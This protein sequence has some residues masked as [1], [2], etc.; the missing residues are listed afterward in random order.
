MK[1]LL[2][3][4][5]SLFAVLVA[6]AYEKDSIFINVNGQNRNMIVFTPTVRT[7]NMPLF[8][9]T[10]GMNQDP[11]YQ[12]DSD[13]MYEMIDTAKFVVTYLRSDGGTWD[14]GGTKDQN[15]VL[16][17]ITE[18]QTRYGCDTNRV[19]WSGFSMGSMLMYHCMP[20]V[21]DKIA[22][23]A[24]TSGIQFSEQP[25]NNL[26]RPVN[27]IHVHAYG[28]SVF[29]Y[30][31]YGIRDYVMHFAT[32]DNATT[33]TKTPNY[34]VNG[35]TW[36]SGDREVW[37]GGTGG[38]QVE[39]FSYN[40]GGHWPMQGNAREIWNFCKRYSLLSEAD[41]YR[42]LYQ[43]ALDMA[44]T[45]ATDVDVNKKVAY[46]SLLKDLDKLH[47]DS[48]D[49]TST[50]AIQSA[51]R[52]INLRTSSLESVI[53]NVIKNS[54]E[55]KLTAF[56]PNLHIYLCFG[57]SNMEGNAVPR[58]QD[59]AG[60]DPRFLSLSAVDMPSYKRTK[61]HWYV[62]RPP[63][64]RDN[65]GMTPVDEFGRSLIR[66][67]PDSVRVGVINVA[68][69]GCAIEMFDEDGIEDYVN[70]QVGWLQSYA[71]NYGRNPFRHLVN[72]A[73]EAQQYGVIRGILLHQ[74]E[75][76]NCQ[77][78][79]PLKVKR[80][81]T[82]LLREL[83]LDEEDVPL[84][85]GETLGQANGGV[86]WGHNNIIAGIRRY[87]PN[88]H[89]VTS[90]GCAGAADGLH[91]TADGYKVL[92]AHYASVMAECLQRY[93]RQDS[94]EGLSLR[95]D[96]VVMMSASACPMRV[97]LTDVDGVDHD[98]TASCSYSSTDGSLVSFSPLHVVSSSGEGTAMV[99]ATY[100][101]PSGVVVSTDFSVRVRRFPL[102]LED[103]TPA[104]LVPD[105]SMTVGN[106]YATLKIQA[107]GL[108]GWRYTRG[109]DVSDYRYLVVDLQ[110][111]S[112]AKPQLRLYGVDDAVS[113]AYY[114]QAFGS[115]RQL[116]VDLHQMTSADGTS[117]DPSDIRLLAFAA[118][119][120][121]GIHVSNLYLTDEDPTPV[122]SPTAAID[123]ADLL[124]Y[125]LLGRSTQ[126]TRRGIIVR[127][128]RK[129][130]R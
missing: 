115:T 1:R 100:T 17:T 69:G 82:R 76:N 106:S 94:L 72:M 8:I 51:T 85:V 88:A 119:N 125:D 117:I 5:F 58:L 53:R 19:Y 30:E 27:L 121:Q 24:P 45:W 25:W 15:F 79:W 73:R 28:D 9:V 98:V 129:V 21:Q 57:Q 47:P 65:T 70:A 56:D 80:V 81:Y 10:H 122:V 105:G 37:S 44:N 109:L 55:V 54:K 62:A 101:C 36:W 61:G 41:Q 75:S 31:E 84:L 130:V 12:Y 83:G 74:G 16:Q 95:A 93:A 111:S 102:T 114:S 89:I 3:I 112:L 110:R 128:G 118:D 6:D 78:D 63:L 33:Y 35:P 116:V 107:G 99:T 60:A 32:Y 46:S 97:V 59:Y 49:M 77:Q 29:G 22:A 68:L 39:L 123:E 91:F 66:Q 90:Q 14:I 87:I 92:G 127:R 11:K 34:Y 38:S 67:L 52:T 23:F 86:C 108:A 2:F 113:P 104:F 48:I 26:K 13:R 42:Q 64:C 18:M 96:S 7:N 4:L 103:F 71:D 40:N 20:N 43:A 50:A 120:N 124:G 126:G